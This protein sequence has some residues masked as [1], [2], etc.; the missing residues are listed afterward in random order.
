MGQG[1]TPGTILVHTLIPE[2]NKWEVLEFEARTAGRS[3]DP[4]GGQAVQ[5]QLTDFRGFLMGAV[6]NDDEPKTMLFT[7]ALQ[8][9]FDVA[10][11]AFKGERASLS[12]ATDTLDQMVVYTEGPG[13]SG[14]YFFADIPGHKASALLW[15]YP[16]IMEDAVGPVSIVAY[17][18]ADGLQMQGVLTLPPGGRP[19]KNLPAV[20][21]PHGGPEARDYALFDW[22]AQAF[23]SR[24]YAVFQPNFRGS[25][26]FGRAFRD[27]GYGQWGR[28]MQTDVSDGLTELA[29]QGIVDPKRA[30]V[31][32]AS[33]GGYVALAGVTL[34]QGLY[35]CAVAI[36]P[37]SDLKIML[38]WREEKF[39][40]EGVVTRIDHAYL[41]V[42]SAGDSSLNAL[43]PARLGRKPTRR[44]CSFT[45][46]RTPPS[47][48]IRV[49]RCRRR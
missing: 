40:Q 27:A 11:R 47:P 2:T 49:R 23:A 25:D 14:T 32:G 3:T 9:R 46:S 1:R 26:G 34:Q 18:A 10:A 39:G 44:C 7:P 24:G 12:S 41:G 6:T 19:A 31:V 22:L 13:D 30:C 42:S 28:K 45:A 29:R 4:F 16:T 48:S 36:A 35:R 17:R 33:Y 5:A 21:L 38:A 20:V 8:A 37:V 43:S 15:A